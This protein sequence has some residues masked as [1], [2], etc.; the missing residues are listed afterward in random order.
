MVVYFCRLLVVA[1]ASYEEVSF[2]F[3]KKSVVIT[4]EIMSVHPPH[5]MTYQMG[6]IIESK[7]NA[8]GFPNQFV[9]QGHNL[10]ST[11]NHPDYT[12]AENM[13]F[14]VGAPARRIPQ[15]NATPRA[16][17][18]MVPDLPFNPYYERKVASNNYVLG[19]ASL[20]TGLW[21]LL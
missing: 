21:M 2:V 1:L 13:T 18:S 5:I 19:L 8:P 17:F 3:Q 7:G 9:T 16:Y 6:K 14:D 4:L 11:Q 15:V 20:V 10:R 12:S